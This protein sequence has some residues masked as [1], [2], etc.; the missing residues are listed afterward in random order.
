M[1]RLI[2]TLCCLGVFTGTKRIVGRHTAS[3]M[4]TTGNRVN[5]RFQETMH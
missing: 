2:I 3:Q 5:V 1:G 4:P